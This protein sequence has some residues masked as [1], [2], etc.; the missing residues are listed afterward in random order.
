MDDA[1]EAEPFITVTRNTTTV[2]HSNYD[3]L[4]VTEVIL[5]LSCKATTEMCGGSNVGQ[6]RSQELRQ[7]FHLLGRYRPQCSCGKAMFS[8]APVIL[9]T[10]EGVYPSMNWGR[11]PLGKHIPACTRADSPLGRHIRACT[12]ALGQIPPDNHYSGRYASY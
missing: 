7:S 3:N 10:G 2:L 1:N 8:Q 4:V 11:H 5:L 12:G 9:F 6:L